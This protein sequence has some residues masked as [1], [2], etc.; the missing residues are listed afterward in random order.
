[1]ADVEGLLPNFVGSVGGGS[2][3]NLSYW[4][5]RRLFR[6]NVGTEM[7]AF[8]VLVCLLASWS[9]CTRFI[10]AYFELFEDSASPF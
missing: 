5:L 2:G 10:P 9:D 4:V 7:G 3:G 8:C 6:S 1:M